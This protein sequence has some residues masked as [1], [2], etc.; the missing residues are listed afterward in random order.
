MPGCDS[1]AAYWLEQAGNHRQERDCAYAIMRKMLAIFGKPH[2]GEWLNQKAYEEA[3]R[4]YE[5]ARAM[6]P[7]L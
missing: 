5:E 3:L 4:V 2:R 6:V 1:S 7:E